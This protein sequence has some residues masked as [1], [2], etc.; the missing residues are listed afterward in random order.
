LLSYKGPSLDIPAV[1]VIMLRP[2][3]SSTISGESSIP[4]IVFL[5]L[6]FMLSSFSLKLKDFPN[7]SFFLDGLW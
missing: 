5:K 2:P 6:K 3:S 7:T 1:V 4:L